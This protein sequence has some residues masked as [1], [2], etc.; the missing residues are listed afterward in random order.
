MPVERQPCTRHWEENERSFHS[1]RYREIVR[2]FGSNWRR[3]FI[4]T[5]YYKSHTSK[6]YEYYSTRRN[7]HQYY[8]NRKYLDA[9]Y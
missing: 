3:S 6:S 2:V 5:L 7:N 8:V 9:S 1:K 4:P